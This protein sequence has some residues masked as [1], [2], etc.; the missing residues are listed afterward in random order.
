MFKNSDY[1]YWNTSNFVKAKNMDPQILIIALGTNDAHPSRWNKLS[2]EF[3]ADYLSMV[4]EFRQDGKKPIIYVC[5]PPPLFGPLKKEQNEV[6]EQKL[7]PCIKEIAKEIGAYIIDYHQPLLGASEGFPDDVHPN[8]AGSALMA[9]IAAQAIKEA[10][11]IEPHLTVSDGKIEQGGIAIVKKGSDVI[12]NPT[13][14]KGSWEWSGPEGF[15]ASGRNVKIENIQRGGIYTAV[16]TDSNGKRSVANFLISVEGEKGPDLIANVKDMEGQW[17]KSDFIQ[18]NPG[19]SVTLKP[20]VE[21]KD[22]GLIWTWK[23]PKGFFA[24]TQEITL[25]TVLPEQT[26][27]YIVTCTDKHGRQN[28][29]A[30]TVKVEGEKVC[31]DLVP[32]INYQN[33]WQRVYEMEVK[34]GDN[35]S[36]GPHPMNGEWHWNGPSGFTSDRR[37]PTIS[38]F[39]KEKAGDYIG[40][41]TNAVGCRLELTIRLKLKK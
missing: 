19:G 2:G 17:I 40:T 7:I 11:V 18:V 16:Y 23:G 32:Y 30:F 31:P 33:G 25:S 36:F 8:D 12:F 38:N 35:V 15:T 24:G 5:L 9:T 28:W 6:V 26:G 34:E 4:N 20:T 27:K 10:Q 22:E 29:K 13:P 21:K 39:S 41:F 37:D 3:K 14:Q 1:P